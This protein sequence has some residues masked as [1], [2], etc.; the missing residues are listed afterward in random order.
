MVLRRVGVLSV[1]KVMGALYALLGLIIGAIYALFAI[2]IGLIG[3]S[4]ASNSGDALIGG[5][6]GVVFGVLSI[7]LFPIFYGILGFIGGIISAFLYNIIA[8]AVGGVELEMDQR[9]GGRVS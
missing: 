7:I 5:A 3:A 9:G 1:G 6:G 4:T 8:R 2:L